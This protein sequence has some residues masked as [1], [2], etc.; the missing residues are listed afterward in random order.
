MGWEPAVLVEVTGYGSSERGGRGPIEHLVSAV[1]ASL[2]YVPAQPTLLR[3]FGTVGWDECW[4]KLARDRGEVFNAYLMPAVGGDGPVIW[5]IQPID[6][7]SEYVGN[8]EAWS[9]CFQAVL[10]TDD[11]VVRCDQFRPL[12]DLMG[13]VAHVAVHVLTGRPAGSRVIDS[14]VAKRK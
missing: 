4:E 3:S 11:G 7:G 9:I 10:D 8:D 1:A 5:V 13:R 2:G 12:M 6:G 14:V